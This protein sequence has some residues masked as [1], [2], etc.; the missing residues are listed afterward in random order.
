MTD[1]YKFVTERS[2]TG[3]SRLEIGAQ[4]SSGHD[5]RAMLRMTPQNMAMS[6]LNPVVRPRLGRGFQVGAV[7][8]GWRYHSVATGGMGASSGEGP[9]RS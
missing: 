8:T 1:H 9:L 4:P 3:L 7:V 6:A 2:P 5:R